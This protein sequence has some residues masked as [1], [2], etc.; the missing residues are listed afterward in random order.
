MNTIND[1]KTLARAISL[2]EN[3]TDGAENILANLSTYSMP[4]VG[5]TGPPGAGKSTLLNALVGNLLEEGK[6]IGLALVD[7]SS[8]FNLGA[9]LGDRLRMSTYFNHPHLYIRSVASRGSLGGLS[10]K[11]IEILEVMRGYPFDYLFV[12][13]VGVG[14]SEVEI[15][16]LADTTVVVLVPEA[17]DGIQAMKA[18]VMEIADILVINKADRAG[19]DTLASLLQHQLQLSGREHIPVLQTVAVEA[20]GIRELLNAIHTLRSSPHNLQRRITLLTEK[21]L[22]LIARKRMRDLCQEEIRQYVE[23]CI[24]QNTFNLYKAVSRFA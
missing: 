7:P 16:G 21:T 3:D 18:G 1:F 17:G 4:V 14:Q 5:F 6:K 20:R 11:M 13:T 24:M 19:A 2:V 9:L 8:P 12:E 22:R 15:A 10:D 23:E